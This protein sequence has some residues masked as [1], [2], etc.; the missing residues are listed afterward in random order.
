MPTRINQDRSHLLTHLCKDPRSGEKTDISGL[1]K[2]AWRPVWAH[3]ISLL[4]S[5]TRFIIQ[6]FFLPV[7]LL[8]PS[9]RNAVLPV[10]EHKQALTARVRQ[11]ACCSGS[12]CWTCGASQAE[13]AF[14]A[15]CASWLSP[16][17]R[18]WA[19][20]CRRSGSPTDS[21]SSDWTTLNPETPCSCSAAVGWGVKLRFSKLI[22]NE[23]IF[24]IKLNLE[25][26]PKL[27]PLCSYKYTQKFLSA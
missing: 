1:R 12:L 10:E 22:S 13:E 5:D 2:W 3:D 6:L 18:R 26:D 17:W 20:P 16:R 15:C 23:T 4:Q 8:H 14:S 25:T 27:V 24:P 21:H 9:G 7:T 19:C 11:A